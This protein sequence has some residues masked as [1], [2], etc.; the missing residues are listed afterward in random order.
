MDEDIREIT[1]KKLSEGWI[2]SWM[3]IEALAINKETVDSALNKHI[4]KIEKEDKSIVIKKEFK[5][6]KTVESPFED[7]KEAH[8]GIVELEILTETLDKLFFIVINYGPSAVEILEPEKITIDMGEAQGIL[9]SMADIIHKFA[10][11][12]MGGLGVET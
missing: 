1:K 10:A 7:V 11:A 12:T 8:S 3:M 4:E 9:N 2:K 5:E 6:T